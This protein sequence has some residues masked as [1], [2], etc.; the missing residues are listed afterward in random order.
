MIHLDLPFESTLCSR[1]VSPRDRPELYPGT[2]PTW[3]FCFLGSRILPVKVEND[4]LVVQHSGR[5]ESLAR[6]LDDR[7]ACP[8]TKRY[9]VLAVGSNAC[10][11]RLADPDKFGGTC[12][13]AIPVLRGHVNDLVSVYAP[14]MADYGSVPSTAMA[15]PGARTD[16]WVTL[17]SEEELFRLDQSEARGTSYDLVEIPDSVFQLDGGIFL[18]PVSAYLQPRALQDPNTCKAI[19]LDCFRVTGAALPAMS[20][21]MARRLV[22]AIVRDAEDSAD[23]DA[24]LH[25]WSIETS[26]PSGARRLNPQAPPSCYAILRGPCG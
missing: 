3:S 9:A 16:I 23:K 22:A 10:P 19:L 8:L 1:F 4:E 21:E 15:L 26:Q 5:L 11:A 7:N 13:T 17:L 14:R 2:R 6:V 12:S 24:R 18:G 25:E 20:Q